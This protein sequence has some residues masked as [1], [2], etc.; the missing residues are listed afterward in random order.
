M[1]LSCRPLLR[2]EKWAEKW[3]SNYGDSDV[4]DAFW[5]NHDYGD[6]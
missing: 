6:L 2:A 5:S 1:L 3:R 4:F